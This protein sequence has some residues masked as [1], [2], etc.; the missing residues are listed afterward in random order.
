ASFNLIYN[1]NGGS[2]NIPQGGLITYNEP[3]KEPSA[4]TR[5][6]HTFKGWNTDQDG[7]GHMWNF[8]SDKMPAGALTLYAIY[9]VN[10]YSIRFE[11]NDDSNTVLPIQKVLY[12]GYIIEPA[13]PNLL[14]YT[15]KGWDTKADGS[16]IAWDFNSNFVLDEEIVLY[17]QWNINRHSVIFNANG[18]ESIMPTDLFV[19]YNGKIEKPFDPLLDGYTFN[20]WNTKIDGSGTNWDF[21]KH[22]MPDEKTEFFAQWKLNYYELIFNCNYPDI[23]APNKQ[24]IG[25]GLLA[26]EPIAPINKGYTL[27]AW[28]TKADGSGTN[29]D[30]K[31]NTMK[32]ANQTL[33]GIWKINQYKVVFVLN[34]GINYTL[35]QVLYEFKTTIVRPTNPKRKDYTFIGWS[36]TNDKNDLWNFENDKMPNSE[37][38]L[39]AMWNHQALDDVTTAPDQKNIIKTG[40]NKLLSVIKVIIGASLL[41]GLSKQKRF[42]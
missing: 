40:D 3:L 4:P 11:L 9:E 15:F 21:D 16:G 30:F 10:S 38:K 7:K 29:W 1:I 23:E 19:D 33:Y 22:T 12:L 25:Y 37:L 2:G 28:N 24:V 39:Y 18:G 42:N 34:D 41:F 8:S 31:N 5:K 36:P 14:G 17:A 6:G 32:A 13:A 26:V 20:G 35:E 27:V